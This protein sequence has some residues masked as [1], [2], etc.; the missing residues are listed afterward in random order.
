MENIREKWECLVPFLMQRGPSCVLVLVASNRLILLF[1]GMPEGIPCGG[2]HKYCIFLYGPFLKVSIPLVLNMGDGLEECKSNLFPVKK[3]CGLKNTLQEDS[4]IYLQHLY[5]SFLKIME[6][7]NLPI[8]WRGLHGL[9]MKICLLWKVVKGFV[10]ICPLFH[11]FV[12]Q[13]FPREK[14]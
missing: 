14:I 6:Y 4:S 12:M 11:S 13:G 2:E 1:N 9:F 10:Q 3:N 7:K 8:P 5:L